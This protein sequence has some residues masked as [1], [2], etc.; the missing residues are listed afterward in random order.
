MSLSSNNSLCLGHILCCGK[1]A[2]VSILRRDDTSDSLE[3]GF[4]SK[5]KKASVFAGMNSLHDS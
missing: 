2:L 1:N 5:N 4:S 3:L